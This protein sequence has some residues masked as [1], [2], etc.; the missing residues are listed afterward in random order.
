MGVGRGK[1]ILY[2]S[3]HPPQPG[4][5]TDVTPSRTSTCV[6]EACTCVQVCTHRSVPCRGEHAYPPHTSLPRPV[7]YG[8]GGTSHAVSKLITMLDLFPSHHHI[9]SPW[10]LSSRTTSL[11]SASPSFS[12]LVWHKGLSSSQKDHPSHT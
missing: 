6:H 8:C 10:P 7:P 12:H 2:K 1:H 5:S 9:L 3:T 11:C 4:H